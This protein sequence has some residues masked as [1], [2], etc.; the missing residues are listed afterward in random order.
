MVPWVA[1]VAKQ[2][3]VCMTSAGRISFTTTSS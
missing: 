3:S 2:A 1:P